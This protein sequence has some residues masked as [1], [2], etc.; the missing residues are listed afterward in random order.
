MRLVSTLLKEI[1]M[2][3]VSIQVHMDKDGVARAHFNT[4][5]TYDQVFYVELDPTT[6]QDLMDIAAGK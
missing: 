1:N 3:S 5:E 4:N 6:I 2:E